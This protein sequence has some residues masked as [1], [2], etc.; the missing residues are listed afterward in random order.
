MQHMESGCYDERRLIALWQMN[1]VGHF[2]KEKSYPAATE[3]LYYKWLTELL[4][5]FVKQGTAKYIKP[6]WAN[7][8]QSVVLSYILYLHEKGD[9]PET[10]FRQIAVMNSFFEWLYKK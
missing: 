9:S 3:S 5:F 4:D 8:N 1:F 2:L 6:Y 10:I 7:C